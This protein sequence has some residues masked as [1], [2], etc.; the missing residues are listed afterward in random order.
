[1]CPTAIDE[2]M[3]YF[4]NLSAFKLKAFY[5]STQNVFSSKSQNEITQLAL[6]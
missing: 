4:T 2:K 6:F 3:Y 1:M 5:R